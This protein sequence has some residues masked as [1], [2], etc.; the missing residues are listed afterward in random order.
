[1][2]RETEA[3]KLVR[4][5]V[6]TTAVN[7][8]VGAA[9][10]AAPF[11]GRDKNISVTFRHTDLDISTA[12]TLA[13]INFL[14]TLWPIACLSDKWMG[15]HIDKSELWMRYYENVT[16]HGTNPYR[17]LE[18]CLSVPL[19]VFMCIIVLGTQDAMFLLSQ[20]TLAVAVVVLGYS[21]EREKLSKCTEYDLRFPWF[22]MAAAVGIF[23][24]QWCT[25]IL[26]A[27]QSRAI[28]EV[29]ALVDWA[30]TISFVIGAGAMLYVMAGASRYMTTIFAAVFKSRMIGAKTEISSQIISCVTK[31]LITLATVSSFGRLI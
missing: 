22:P 30:P 16:K 6:G 25:I 8:L 5:L 10:C 13:A 11:V 15:R 18:Y 31:V 7:L 28:F 23:L 3:A 2:S 17:W 27:A 19:I 21:Q 14:G 26:N 20:M 12:H 1:M 4:V 24:C 9:C 29:P